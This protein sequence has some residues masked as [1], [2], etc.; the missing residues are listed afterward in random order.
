[1]EA[2]AL[3]DSSYRVVEKEI[4]GGRFVSREEWEKR[5]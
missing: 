4:E 2:R 1:M 5:D 3:F